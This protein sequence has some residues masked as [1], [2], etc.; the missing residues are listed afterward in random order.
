MNPVTSTARMNF[1]ILMPA[2]LLNNG[3]R[4]PQDLP[5]TAGRRQGSTGNC[6]PGI[7]QAALKM[8]NKKLTGGIY[9]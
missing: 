6:P 7:I 3:F 1:N 8:S 9:R 2:P 4:T 5:G